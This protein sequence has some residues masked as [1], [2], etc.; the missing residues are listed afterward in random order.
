VC[1]EPFKAGE[2]IDVVREAVVV[3][4]YS[5]GPLGFRLKAKPPVFIRHS[6]CATMGGED[7]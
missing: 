7:G 6:A 1:N 2:Q 4:F 5:S 3:N